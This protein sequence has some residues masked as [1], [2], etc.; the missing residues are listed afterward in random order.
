MTY[1]LL[2]RENPFDVLFL[3]ENEIKEWLVAH[4]HKGKQALYDAVHRGH[5]DGYDITRHTDKQIDS[6]ITD[7][8][9]QLT[10]GEFYE[11]EQK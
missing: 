3:D 8:K 6:Y 11:V 2:E 4:G 5:I 1:Y 9:S 7:Y 10:K